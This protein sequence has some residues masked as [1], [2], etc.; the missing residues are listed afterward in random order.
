MSGTTALTHLQ[1]IGAFYSIQTVNSVSTSMCS[2]IKL[3][4]KYVLETMS[5]CDRNLI[6]STMFLFLSYSPVPTHLPEN[7]CCLLLKIYATYIIYV[8]T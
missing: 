2:Y 4:L 6:S 3:I 8:L 1:I 7:Q 5:M